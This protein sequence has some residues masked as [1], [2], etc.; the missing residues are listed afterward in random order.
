MQ[1]SEVVMRLARDSCPFSSWPHEDQFCVAE[2]EPDEIGALVEQDC[3]VV[4]AEFEPAVL[5]QAYFVAQLP[6]G[7]YF[8][9]ASV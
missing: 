4:G 5:E 3:V 2:V 7:K 1:I 9:H 6:R 8:Q